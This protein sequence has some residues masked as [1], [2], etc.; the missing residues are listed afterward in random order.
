MSGSSREVTKVSSG[1]QSG[2]RELGGR[3]KTVWTGNLGAAAFMEENGMLVFH[4]I[5]V[6]V[7]VSEKS[8][9]TCH[10]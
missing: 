9:S 6:E 4:R 7:W 5:P 1:R 10:P 8:G 3:C 2:V